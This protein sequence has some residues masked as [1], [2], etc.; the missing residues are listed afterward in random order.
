MDAIYSRKEQIKKRK[1]IVERDKK[2]KMSKN[3]KKPNT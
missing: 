3:E 2:L 1:K